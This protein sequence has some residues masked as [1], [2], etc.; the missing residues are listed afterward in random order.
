[1]DLNYWYVWGVPSLQ[2]L[3][4]RLFF[5]ITLALVSLGVDTDAADWSTLS[6]LLAAY[7]LF[8]L[9]AWAALFAT[10]QA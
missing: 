6:S 5:S 2:S 9:V 1:M 3:V 7:V 10:R 8:G 4:D